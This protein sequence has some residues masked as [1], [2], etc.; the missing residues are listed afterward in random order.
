MLETMHPSINTRLFKRNHPLIVL[1][2]IQ[3]LVSSENMLCKFR[4]GEAFQVCIMLGAARGPRCAPEETK[5]KWDIPLDNGVWKKQ[6]ASD[7]TSQGFDLKTAT[8]KIH[9]CIRTSPNYISLKNTGKDGDNARSL[10]SLN[11]GHQQNGMECPGWEAVLW[12]GQLYIRAFTV[13]AQ[14]MFIKFFFKFYF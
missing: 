10:N 14:S 1:D 2:L 8:L 4:S 3:H 11:H 6:N 9:F 13:S 12:R 7:P 5:A